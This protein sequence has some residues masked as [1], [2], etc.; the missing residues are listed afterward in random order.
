MPNEA[1]LRALEDQWRDPA[2]RAELETALA[3]FA[4]AL[5]GEVLR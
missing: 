1:A 5:R 2:R 4:V 3:D